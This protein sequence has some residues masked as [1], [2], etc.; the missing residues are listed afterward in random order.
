[1][2]NKRNEIFDYKPS[3]SKDPRIPSLDINKTEPQELENKE[4]KVKINKINN[5]QL[6]E[7]LK[8]DNSKAKNLIQKLKESSNFVKN[9]LSNSNEIKNQVHEEN[10]ETQSKLILP[11]P[12][13]DLNILNSF[14]KK[15]EKSVNLINK[16][17]E[18]MKTLKNE[19]HIKLTEEE[20]IKI[21]K[22][23]KYKIVKVTNREI[24]IKNSKYGFEI[25]HNN[26]DKRYWVIT[27]CFEELWNPRKIN[28]INLWSGNSFIGYGFNTLDQCIEETKKLMVSGKTGNI[29]WKDFVVDWNKETKRFIVADKAKKFTYEEYKKIVKWYHENKIWILVKQEKIKDYE[30]I[31]QEAKE[32]RK[33][34]EQLS[35]LFEIQA[36]LIEPPRKANYIFSYPVE[37]PK[38]KGKDYENPENKLYE[39]AF[40]F[41]E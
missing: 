31:M 39:I 19:P 3:N 8:I 5:E 27:I 37:N 4:V 13:S 40:G 23:F 9:P 21:M 16:T 34:G 29:I 33:N 14:S 7:D 2:K 32:K 10:L 25:H 20:K 12:N 22:N 1:M 26:T 15:R 18:V 11:D 41:S 36:K 30:D 24:L 35:P 38:Y 6:N 17:Q 28:Y